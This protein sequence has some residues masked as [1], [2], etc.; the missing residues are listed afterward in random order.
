MRFSAPNTAILFSAALVGALPVLL[1][2]DPALSIAWVALW[3]APAGA[4][5]GATSGGTSRG[6]LAALVPVSWVLAGLRLVGPAVPSAGWAALVVAGLF[7]VGYGI[8]AWRSRSAW[9]SASALL[10][11]GAILAWLPGL[12]G[13][14]GTPP[15]WSPRTAAR[16]LGLAPTSIAVESAG[17]DWMHH[18]AVYSNVGTDRMGPDV[19]TAWRGFLAGP[20]LLLVGCALAAAGHRVA[21]D[22]SMTPRRED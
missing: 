11:L 22:R 8:G 16:L 20:T 1:A 21:A 4:L 19:R 3:A 14:A 2:R 18:S 6:L 17:V 9:S 13:F 10:V 7:G 12:D 15:P 5:V